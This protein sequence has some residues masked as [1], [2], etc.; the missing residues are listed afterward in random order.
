MKKIFFL[1]LVFTS[2]L[3]SQDINL[4]KI[5]KNATIANKPVYLFIHQTD[6]GYCESMIEFTFDDDKVKEEL[7][8][9]VVVDLNIRNSG[10]ISY[11]GFEG[12]FK[13]FVVDIGFNFYPSSLFF[14]KSGE[15]MYGQPG[16]IQ[17]KE[18][19]TLLQEMEVDF[20]QTKR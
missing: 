17:E 14:E 2:L 4:D 1:L 9:F 6:C 8:K 18:F 19:L 12:T 3:F 15:L 10:K 13:E 20:K 16:Y 5:I 7:K 11:Q